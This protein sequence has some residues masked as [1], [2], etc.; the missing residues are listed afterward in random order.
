MY[1]TCYF[2]PFFIGE[3]I[4]EENLLPVIAT[5]FNGTQRSVLVVFEELIPESDD[6]FTFYDKQLLQYYIVSLLKD[7][8][9]IQFRKVNIRDLDRE[10]IKI[11]RARLD[12]LK[13]GVAMQSQ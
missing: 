5:S 3:A 10:S 9:V 7:A 13:L 11:T 2:V 12:K 1:K 8:V 4:L 6:I